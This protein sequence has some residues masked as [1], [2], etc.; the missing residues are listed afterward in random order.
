MEFIH[1]IYCTFTAYGAL[2]ALSQ[3]PKGLFTHSLTHL[4][5]N[6]VLPTPLAAVQGEVSDQRK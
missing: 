2:Q 4:Q 1:Q 3:H 5:T 6:R